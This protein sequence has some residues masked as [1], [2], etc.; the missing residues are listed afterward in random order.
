MTG[1][2]AQAKTKRRMRNGRLAR[3]T[4]DVSTGLGGRGDKPRALTAGVTGTG[5]ICGLT[6]IVAF[7][8]VDSVA[9]NQ[10]R[11]G[12]AADPLILDRAAY[13]TAGF[14]GH[15]D[16]TRTLTAG[17]TGTGIVGSLTIIV[18]FTDIGAITMYQI[19]LPARRVA[20][21]RL[22]RRINCQARYRHRHSGA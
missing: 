2:Q 17:V 12:D 7:A 4:T 5:I 3:L 21:C 8:D 13:I 16:K 9:V 11:G 10:L 15:C 18:P 20:R 19:R 1:S 14:C 22:A 6:V